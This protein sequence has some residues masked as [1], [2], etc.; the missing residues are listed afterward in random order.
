MV[1]VPAGV[2]QVWSTTAAGGREEAQRAASA[3][4]GQRWPGSSPPLFHAVGIWGGEHVVAC[5][6]SEDIPAEAV[7]VSELELEAAASR[8]KEGWAAP[9]ALGAGAGADW[10]S[11]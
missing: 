7:A 4:V 3:A 2:G 10:H 11:E 1:A 5:M 6:M 8:G 9:S